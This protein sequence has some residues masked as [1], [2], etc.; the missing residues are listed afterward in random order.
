[1]H[2]SFN[3]RLK[4]LIRPEAGRALLGSLVAVAVLLSSTRLKG[5][6]LGYQPFSIDVYLDNQ[7]LI[8]CIDPLTP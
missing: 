8:S 2:S 5:C 7:A 6:T 3:R 4:S 1:M